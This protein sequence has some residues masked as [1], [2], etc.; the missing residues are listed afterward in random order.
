MSA[1]IL[2][3]DLS[4]RGAAAVY[5]P[6]RWQLCK[7]QTLR[8]GV[9]GGELPKDATPMQKAERLMQIATALYDFA[10]T[11]SRGNDDYR[12]YVEDYA[13]GLAAFSGMRIAE[14]GGAVKLVFCQM[15]YAVTPVNISA[16]R[17]RFLG[18]R[19]VTKGS[20]VVTHRLLK[21]MKTGFKTADEG[22]AFV[23]AN[24]GLEDAGRKAIQ[25]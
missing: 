2:G 21:E 6:E 3:L 20:A 7:W 24:W 14:L 13:Y 25:C 15:G 22:D 16:A 4:L 8:T 17:K 11:A 5:I 1:S 19:Y 23:V 18:D 9:F 12:V 10:D